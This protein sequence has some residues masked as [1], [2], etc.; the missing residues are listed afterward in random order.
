MSG[1]QNPGVPPTQRTPSDEQFPT[2]PSVG[3]TFPDF[4][5]VNQRGETVNLTTARAGAPAIVAFERSA[6][7]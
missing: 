2:G 5:L 6:L 4:T 7:W 3:E 1:E